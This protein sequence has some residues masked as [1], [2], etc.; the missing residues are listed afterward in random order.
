MGL[1][2]PRPKLLVETFAEEAMEERE[3]VDGGESALGLST[4]YF[5]QRSD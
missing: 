1:P 4:C 2:M 3:A 5:G